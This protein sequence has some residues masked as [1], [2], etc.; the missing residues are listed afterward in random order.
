MFRVGLTGGIGCGKSTVA[1]LFS[2]LGIN[3]IDTDVIA[4]QIM[5]PDGPAYEAIVDT[6]G[7]EILTTEN[8]INR[9]KLAKIIFHS[10][11][12]KTLLEDLLH[13]LIWLVTE[14]QA[15]ASC[16]PYCIIAVPLLFEGQHQSRFN[17]TLL[18][19]CPEQEQ[20]KRVKKRDNRSTGDIKAII[21]NQ[22]PATE[23]I[24][25]ADHVIINSGDVNTLEN[26]V[27]HLHNKFL[28]LAAKRPL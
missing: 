5:Q 17:T 20:I 18:I 11:E 21:K 4:H 10:A 23:K 25:L 7:D 9:K 3:V 8:T 12:K 26:E 19:D 27:K 14:Q 1:S 15:A 24:K 28:N 6:F 16:S 2:K 22:M 13:P